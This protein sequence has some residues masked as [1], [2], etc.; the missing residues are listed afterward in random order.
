MQMKRMLTRRDFLKAAGTGL[1]GAALF[2]MTGCGGG[3]DGTGAL[4]TPAAEEPASDTGATITLTWWDYFSEGANAEAMQAQL[5]R[6]MDEHPN[7]TIERTALPFAEL[8]Q[9]LLQGATAGQLPDIA[10]IDN[11][12]HQAFAALGVLADLTERVR[13]WGQ[14]DAYFEGPWNST[15][16]QGKNYGIPDNSNCLVLWYNTDFTQAA[17]VAP[18]STWDELRTA[19]EQLTEGGRFG[20]AVSAVRSEEGTFQWLPFL[21]SAGA[22]IPNLDSEG[23]RAAL[24]LWVDL[25]KAGYMSQGILGWNQ[26]DVRIQFQNGQA[27]MMVNGPWQIPVLKEE[28]PDLMWDVATL[29]KDKESASILGGENRS[30]TKDS[31]N[32]DAAWD[33]LTWSQQPENLKQYL[34]QAGKL[35]S[36]QDLADDPHWSGDPVLKVFIEQLRVARPRAYGA[37]YPEISSALQEMLQAAISGQKSVDAAV[38]D[39]QAKITPLL[40]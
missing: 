14:A 29:P 9:K 24:Q 26:Q 32:I 21:W 30:I 31:K 8:K 38:A 34:I 4:A 2:G 1:A 27:A 11:P 40:Q 16:Y 23:G 6:Y 10:V 17:D 7:V 12:D 37:K 39:A 25:V 18:P 3:E 19:A 35:P 20:L 28:S 22:D 36:R 15:V 5:Q 13:S 33:L